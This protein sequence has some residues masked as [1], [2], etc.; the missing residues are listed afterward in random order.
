MFATRDE[1]GKYISQTYPLKNGEKLT[2]D[3][4]NSKTRAKL[5]S[6]ILNSF[7][8]KITAIGNDF[9]YYCSN[10]TTLTL[11]KIWNITSIGNNFLHTAWGLTNLDLSMLSSIDTIGDY[12]LYSNRNLISVDLSSLK[13]VH[14]VGG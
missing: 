12:F 3:Y 13:N 4:S 6:V 1:K 5:T 10:I 11:P 2:I 7:D 8:P 14:S 9:L